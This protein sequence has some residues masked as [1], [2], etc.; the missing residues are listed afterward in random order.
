[1]KRSGEYVRETSGLR[2][3]VGIRK[4]RN[5][6]GEGAVYFAV[7]RSGSDDV[8]S[9]DISPVAPFKNTFWWSNESSDVEWDSLLR[10]LKNVALPF[11]KLHESPFDERLTQARVHDDFKRLT[12]LAAPFARVDNAYW[13]KRG[14]IYDVID[15]EFLG[16]SAFAFVYASVWHIALWRDA[17]HISGPADISRVASQ[18]VGLKELDLVPNTTLFYLGPACE[19][20][21]RI[22]ADAIIPLVLDHFARVTTPSDVWTY[23]RPEYRSSSYLNPP[24]SSS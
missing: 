21:V 18:T 14:D 15:V 1:M 11:F 13:R 8:R 19:G 16:D 3:T 7:E 12:T 24:S 5:V 20:T 17:D 23:V 9:F 2:Q 4:S 22:D 10:Q 6:P